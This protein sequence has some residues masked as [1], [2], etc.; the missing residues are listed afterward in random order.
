VVKKP[1]FGTK[2]ARRVVAGRAWCGDL[3][4][5][6]R[7]RGWVRGQDGFEFFV[8]AAGV[9]RPLGF[10]QFFCRAADLLG[11][12]EPGDGFLMIGFHA[13]RASG[14]RA[15]SFMRRLIQVSLLP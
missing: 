10:H 3:V 15:A 11:G 13:S 9:E 1:D 4:A 6:A 12:D 5:V 7:W 2:K 8:G 14:V